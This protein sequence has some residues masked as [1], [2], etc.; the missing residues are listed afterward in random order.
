MYGTD[1]C[2]MA[3]ILGYSSYVIN[4]HLQHNSA[5]N[6]DASFYKSEKALVGKYQNA[7][8]LRLIKSS[9]AKLFISHSKIFSQIFN[10]K[11]I[12]DLVFLFAKGK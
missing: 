4:F 5:G 8:K 9:C 12:K 3:D 10:I 2:L 6:K 7:F 11:I 1:L